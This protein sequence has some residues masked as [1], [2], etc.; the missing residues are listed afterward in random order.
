[1]ATPSW[2]N[3]KFSDLEACAAMAEQ[4]ATNAGGDASEEEFAK[5]IDTSLTSSYFNLKLNSVRAYGFLDYKAGRIKLTPLG[6]KVATPTDADDRIFAL[7]A[8]MMNFSAFKTLTERYQGKNEPEKK[9]TENALASEGK[10]KRE[11]ASKWADCFLKSARYAGLF[12]HGA[13][14]RDAGI[15]IPK[16]VVHPTQRPI[17]NSESAELGDEDK[18]GWLTYPVPVPGGMARIFVPSDLSRQAWEKLKK[19]LDAIEP[20]KE[21]D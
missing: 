18:P 7:L 16:T 8:A 13:H 5:M 1:M 21:G 6:E 14:F 4:V 10:I 19:L 12:K 9:F 15:K 3:A 17:L 20:A 2:L 11:D